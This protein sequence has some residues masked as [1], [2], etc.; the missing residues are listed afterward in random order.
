MT[1]RHVTFT[2]GAE[3]L[4]GT[5]DDG[6][7]PRGLLI[8][9]GGS[10]TR[11]GAFD[12]HA[13]LAASLAAHGQSVF[14][15]DR[16][17]V[18]DASGEDLGFLHSEEDITAALTQFRQLCPDLRHIAAYGNCDA[19]SALMLGRGFGLDALVLA[20]PWT[21]DE[22]SEKQTPPAA[23]RARYLDKLRNPRELRR[24]MVGEVSLGNLANSLKDMAFS[25]NET[26]QL[27]KDI[28]ASL[29]GFSGDVRILLAGK[30]RTAGAF[31]AN[32]PNCDQPAFRRE[33]A[34]HGFS[35]PDDQAWLE[36]QI[37]AAIE[38]MA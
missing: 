21:F 27:G 35:D 22:G 25:K 15:F 37:V 33:G 29:T 36:S 4:V 31:L 17:G 23:I 3:T 28:T 6:G 2:L 11:S 26:S 16:R 7:G 19:A 24:L 38:A 1:R 32:C 8:V 34:D 9:S 18:G 13:R 30:D 14:R 12:S 10:E 20:N 5:L